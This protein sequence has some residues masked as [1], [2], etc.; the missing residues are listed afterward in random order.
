MTFCQDLY[1]RNKCPYFM[2]NIRWYWNVISYILDCSLNFLSHYHMYREMAS[3]LIRP[4]GPREIPSTDDYYL[5]FIDLS[6]W[7]CSSPS[8]GLDSFGKPLSAE[9][10]TL[11]VTTA[12]LQSWSSNRNNFMMR[13]TKTWGAVLK[14]TALRRPKTTKGD[15]WMMLASAKIIQFGTWFYSHVIGMWW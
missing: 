6:K 4:I 10:F 2:W 7:I 8:V 5:N 11:C 12:K 9:I 3:D 14:L 13:V 1:W 15:E